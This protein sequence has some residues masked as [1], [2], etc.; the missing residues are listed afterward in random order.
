[1]TFEP[2]RTKCPGWVNGDSQISAIPVPLGKAGVGGAQL[3]LPPINLSESPHARRAS[4]SI[5][6]TFA[7]TRRGPI[8]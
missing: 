5:R 3:S 1:M 7:P 8:F 6:T 4:D 2:R